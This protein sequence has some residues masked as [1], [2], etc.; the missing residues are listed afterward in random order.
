MTKCVTE[1]TKTITSYIVREGH[2]SGGTGEGPE[3]PDSLAIFNDEGFHDEF[4]M[5]I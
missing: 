3:W 1:L 5:S 2:S 4:W